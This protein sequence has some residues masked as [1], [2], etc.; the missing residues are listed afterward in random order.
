MDEQYVGMILL[1]KAGDD[2]DTYLEYH[3]KQRK[4][5]E[6]FLAIAEQLPRVALKAKEIDKA[7]SLKL[8]AQLCD[9]L[10]C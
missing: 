4:M 6:Q 10:I 1:H 3:I 8:L 5:K 2:L 7:V 9:P